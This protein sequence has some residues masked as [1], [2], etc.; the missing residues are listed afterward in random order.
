MMI[1]LIEDELIYT[2]EFPLCPYEVIVYK[3]EHPS[4]KNKFIN[5]T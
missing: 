1:L 4:D 3:S 5:E 2:E